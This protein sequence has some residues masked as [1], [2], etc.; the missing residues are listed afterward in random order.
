MSKT[1]ISLITIIGLH[2]TGSVT[3]EEID[4]ASICFLEKEMNS[5]FLRN[6]VRFKNHS[7]ESLLLSKKITINWQ[8][9]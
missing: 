1:I 9:Y 4:A 6:K 3:I 8:K 7:I 5:F 2:H